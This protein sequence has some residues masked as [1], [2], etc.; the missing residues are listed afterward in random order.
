[1]SDLPEHPDD[2]MGDLPPEF[3]RLFDQ[4]GGPGLMSQIARM[5]GGGG[6]TGPVDWT[7]ARQVALQVASDG[8][9]APTEAER[10]RYERA[11]SVAEH[12]LDG[13]TLP[14]PPDAGR[15]EVASR[16]AWIDAAIG[17]MRPLI[18]PVAQASTHAMTQL[19]REQLDGTD[20]ES[21]GLGPLAG[22]LGALGDLSRFIAPMGATL[23][24]L[25]SGQVLGQLARQLLGQYELGLPTAPRATA[26]HLTVNHADAFDGWD[27]D[28]TE[29]AVALALAEGAYRRLYH[30]VPWMEAHLHG[31][32]ARFAAGTDIDA[33]RLQDVA[34]ELMTGV[35]PEDPA[36][37]QR[38]MEQAGRFELEPTPDQRRILERIQGIVLLIQAWARR[39][40]DRA[41]GDRLPNRDRIDEVLRRR[42]AT[43]GDGEELLSRLLGLDLKPEDESIGD[44]FVAAVEAAHGP[45][46]LRRALA[47]P[48]NLPD[49]AELADPSQWLERMTA[50]ASVPDDAAALFDGLDDAPVE[51]SAEERRRDR[52]DAP[53]QGPGAGEAGGGRGDDAQD[54]ADDDDGDGSVGDAP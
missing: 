27:L 32:V 45:E 16:R 40:I 42:R 20:L 6:P 12:W 52:D 24:G 37:I 11:Q 3:R 41:A 35:D 22:M 15:M 43:K 25:Q 30:A 39:E 54:R 50:G 10:E 28:P 23:A 38:A 2:P 29:V 49:T 44:A 31:L 33:D 8:D 4:L 26:M 1:M 17:T 5:F 9:R 14:A 34:R 53:G 7:L 36:A 21:V 13:S 47:H 51:P 48:E 19:V 18:E 46:G